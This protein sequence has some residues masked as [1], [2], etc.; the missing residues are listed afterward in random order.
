MTGSIPALS[1]FKLELYQGTLV[2]SRFSDIY[3]NIDG[4]KAAPSSW[5]HS[6]ARDLLSSR[7][8]SRFP[9]RRNFFMPRQAAA[10][11][12]WSGATE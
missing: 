11:L 4:Y 10:G 6:W 7:S 9:G 8:C 5:S 12:R 2:V 3:W 1:E